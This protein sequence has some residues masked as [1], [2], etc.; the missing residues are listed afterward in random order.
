MHHGLGPVEAQFIGDYVGKRFAT[1]VN[2]AA[3]DAYFLVSAR[4]GCNCPPR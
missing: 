4:V 3:V 1:Y 2:D